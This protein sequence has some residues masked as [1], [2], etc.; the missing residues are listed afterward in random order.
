[1][2]MLKVIEVLAESDKSFDDAAQNAV[3]QASA[4]VRNVKSVYIKEMNAAVENGRIT[5]Y[6]VNAKVSF[7][8]DNQSAG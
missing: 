3:T 4:S 5:S 8:L 1:M 2:S 7:L 6:R